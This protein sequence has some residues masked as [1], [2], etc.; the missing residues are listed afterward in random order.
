MLKKLH[1][2]YYC[3]T[4]N[5]KKVPKLG[6]QGSHS[7]YLVDCIALWR[8]LSLSVTEV[9]QGKPAPKLSASIKRLQLNVTNSGTFDW[10][11]LSKLWRCVLQGGVGWVSPNHA[12]VQPVLGA[13]VFT[14]MYQVVLICFLIAYDFFIFPPLLK[15]LLEK[16]SD[17]FEPFAKHKG[18]HII[19]LNHVIRDCYSERQTILVLL[20]YCA[21]STV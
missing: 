15:K 7:L 12:A 21:I 4:P 18:M 19:E 5:T 8:C 14:L 10:A 16:L 17:L 13:V 2:S 20:C 3:L 1:L 9:A 11:G 6:A